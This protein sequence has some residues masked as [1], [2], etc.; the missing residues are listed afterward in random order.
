MAVSITSFQ[1]QHPVRSSRWEYGEKVVGSR[2]ASPVCERPKKPICFGQDSRDS[3][4]AGQ[5]ESETTETK[6]V[7]R[8]QQKLSAN[9]GSHWFTF[10]ET[11]T[12]TL[13]SILA[14]AANVMSAHS[15]TLY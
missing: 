8:W 10:Q 12:D 15:K 7:A 6:T 5:P 9:C 14:F 3:A 11:G 13:C 4:L 1:N 2:K